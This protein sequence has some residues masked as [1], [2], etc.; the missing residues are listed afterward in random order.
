MDV[1]KRFAML[2]II[3]ECYTNG[4]DIESKECA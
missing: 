4:R 3:T 1:F 2:I